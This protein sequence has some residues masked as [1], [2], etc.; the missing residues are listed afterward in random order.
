[1]K[2]VLSSLR[3]RQLSGV[4]CRTCARLLRREWRSFATA[5]G[6]G[7]AEIYDVVCVGGGPAGLSLLAALRSHPTTS[8]LRLALIES[9]SLTP[10]RTF[11]PQ[12]DSYSNRCSSLTPA[13]VGFLDGIGAWKHVRR[14]RVMPYGGMRVWDG[15]SG[16]SIGFDV[17]GGGGSVEGVKETEGSNGGVVAYMNENVNLTSAL[18]RRIE[19]LGGVDILEGEKVEDIAFGEDTPTA[20][21]TSWPVITTSSGTRLAARLLV[22]ADGANSPVRTFA[23]IESRGW[24]YNRVGLVATLKISGPGWGG[25]GKKIAYQ[26]FLPTGPVAMLPLPGNMSTLVWSTTPAL[27]ARLKSLSP[28]DFCAMV[29]A[30]F[31]LRTP[32]LKFLHTIEG[33]QK[34]EVSWRETHTKFPRE[35]V[36]QDVVAVQPGSIA[37]F[38]LKFRHADSYISQR[39]AL[40]G[41]A[42]HSVHPLAGQGLN[43]GQGDVQSLVDNIIYNVDHGA[44]LGIRMN[45]EGYERE[46]YWRNHVLMGVVDKLHKLYATENLGVVGVR[47]WGLGV[48]DRLEGCMISEPQ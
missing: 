37:S 39:I 33:G 27:A 47:S 1:M 40:V 29:N 35:Q 17:D 24:D 21:L 25:E 28:E 15:V 38:P 18:L 42:A 23:G 12:P 26:R 31:R 34:D 32:D 48:V 4:R 2:P 22:G 3:A 16:E 10:L 14:E 19:E 7:D 45:L 13:S 9:Q 36:P 8:R 5:S 6:A 30:A 20:D 11:A 43:Q 41:D 46:R 44:D